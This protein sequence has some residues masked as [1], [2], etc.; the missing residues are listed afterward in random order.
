MDVHSLAKSNTLANCNLI[1]SWAPV[2]RKS[3]LGCQLLDSTRTKDLVDLV[4][5][6]RLIWPG[7]YPGESRASKPLLFQLRN[8]ALHVGV[9]FNESI[10]HGH[11]FRADRT[12]QQ[13]V[14]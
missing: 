2:R 5:G 12:A 8:D 10:D 1:V 9:F 3:D 6:N 13:S 4:G 7:S 14:E 11:H